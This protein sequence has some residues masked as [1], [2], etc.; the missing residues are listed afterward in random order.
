MKTQAESK[1][2]KAE[3]FTE[4]V[5]AY[6]D[7]MYTWALHK[8][9]D[10][11]LAQD[12]V[13]DSFLAAF[14]G[15]DK[16]R[17]D[18][19]AKTWLFS[20][21]RNK[22]IDHYRKSSS[23]KSISLDEEEALQWTDNLFNKKGRWENQMLH[24]QWDE[25]ESLLDD[26]DFKQVFEACKSKLPKKWNAAIKAKY[27]EGLDGKEICKELDLTPSNYW[28]IIHRAKLMLKACIETQWFKTN[29]AK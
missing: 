13:Q 16:F 22:I 1:P 11:A 17:A 5:N 25:A 29:K 2:D 14:K 21:L 4:W 28:Q 26:S 12:L 3:V 8:V 24:S 9:S 19:Q 15:L 20:I 18:S 7:A 6:S 23:N 27:T 10:E